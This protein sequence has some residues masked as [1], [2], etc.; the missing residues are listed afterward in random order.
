MDLALTELQTLI[1]N[2]AKEFMEG[3]MPKDKVLE[4][5][6]SPS[7][8]SEEVWQKMCEVGWAGMTI[9]EEFGDAIGVCVNTTADEFQESFFANFRRGFIA[10]VLVEQSEPTVATHEVLDDV[11][12]EWGGCA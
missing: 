11:P 10:Q 4:I 6:D 1:Q 8:F 12:S 5:D 9:P 2:L 3:E 7:G